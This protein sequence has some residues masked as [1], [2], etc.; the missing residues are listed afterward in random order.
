MNILILCIFNETY[1]NNKLQNIQRILLETQRQ[2]ITNKFSIDY[3]FITYDESITEEFKLIGDTLF[4]KGNESLLNIVD[5]TIK[6]LRYFTNDKEYDFI[7]RTNISTAYNYNLLYNHLNE[8]PK[9]NLY[10]GGLLFKL[11]WIDEPCGITKYNIEK[12]SLD[13]LYYFQGTCIILSPDVV[14]FILDNHNNLIH[15]VVDDV[16]ICLFIKN[17]L[18]NVYLNFL[19]NFKIPIYS[20]ICK[21]QKLYDIN[22]IFYRHKSCNDDE[23]IKDMINT[24]RI[25]NIVT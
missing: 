18:P 22:S 16:S 4:I 19:N 8:L 15:E 20:K 24:T 11:G 14:K 12:Y 9:N 3:Y 25:I 2:K 6:S 5:K 23:D 10:N 13:G 17:Y 7:V 1:R 21:E